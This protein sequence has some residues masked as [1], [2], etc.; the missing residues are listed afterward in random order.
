MCSLHS[1]TSNTESVRQLSRVS[2]N[3][4]KPFDPLA[5]D[6]PGHGAPVARREN[7]GDVEL[8]KK[9]VGLPAAAACLYSATRHHGT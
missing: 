6:F 9:V 8:V 7:D 5:A 4:D 3:R 2:L 1:M